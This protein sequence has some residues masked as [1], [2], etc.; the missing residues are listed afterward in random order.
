MRRYSASLTLSIAFG[1]R[2]PTF[3]GKDKSGFSVKE[4]FMVQ[5]SQAWQRWLGAY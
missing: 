5:S 4:F 1:K 2:A 3:A